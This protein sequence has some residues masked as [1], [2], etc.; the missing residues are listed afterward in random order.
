[1]TAVGSTPF[2]LSRIGGKAAVDALVG[3]IRAAGRLALDLYAAGA[4]GRATRKPDRSPVTE[5]DRAV[6]NHLREYMQR[7]FP[8][9]GF[10]GEETGEDNATAALR[11]VVDP[12]DGTR[13]FLRGIPTWSILVGLECDRVPVLGIAHFP[14][15]GDMLVGIQGQGATSN[16]QPLKVSEVD[17]LEHAVISHG[18]LLQFTGSDH[19]ALLLA[20]G[21]KTYTQRGFTDFDGYRKL[22]HGQVDA[23]I[24]PGIQAWDICPAAVLVREAGGRFTSF[25]GKES[26]HEGTSIASNGRIHD[27]LIQLVREAR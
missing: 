24:E 14:A 26:I 8:G 13:S 18:S 19:D 12:I 20:L 4:A 11:F 17:S 7:A 6:E 22:L 15:D 5:A 3:E 27:A 23:M 21:R 2:D 16:G 25:T 10:L 1:M 9:V